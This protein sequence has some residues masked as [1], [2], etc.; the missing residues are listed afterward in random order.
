MSNILIKIDDL[1]GT[2]IAQF[3]AEHINDMRAISPPE[4]KHALAIDEL[5]K[6]DISFWSMYQ[7]TKLVG[8]GALKRINASHGEIKSMR[9]SRCKRGN[10]QHLLIIVKILIVFLCLNL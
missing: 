6:P 5:R 4:S 9:I 2:D 10:A 8:C 3:L 7:N 1:T